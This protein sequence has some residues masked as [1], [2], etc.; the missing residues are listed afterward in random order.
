MRGSLGGATATITSGMTA[1]PSEASSRVASR[2]EVSGSLSIT[3]AI[4]PMP[5]ATPSISGS[6]GRCDSAMPPAA[7]MNRAGKVGPPRKL[8]RDTP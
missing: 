6:P 4:A 8:L 3:T 7:P 2:T 5:M 1:R